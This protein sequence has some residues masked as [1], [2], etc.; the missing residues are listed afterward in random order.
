MSDEREYITALTVQAD[1]SIT[2]EFDTLGK[3]AVREEVVRCVDCV[4]CREHDMRAYGSDHNR[5]L[6]HHFSMSSGAGWPVEPDGFC[7]WGE[8]RDA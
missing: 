4:H 2:L 1:G 5:L 8:R 7:A 3:S 6:C